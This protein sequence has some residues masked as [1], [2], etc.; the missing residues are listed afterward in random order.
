MDGSWEEIH[1]NKDVI[2]PSWSSE[3]G[4]ESVELELLLRTK[5]R[6]IILWPEDCPDNGYYG[7]DGYGMS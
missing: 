4:E 1:T 2:S 6:P 7:Q 5:L 3:E